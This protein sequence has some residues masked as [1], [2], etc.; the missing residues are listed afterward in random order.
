MMKRKMA[1]MMTGALLAMSATTLPAFAK[2]SPTNTQPSVGAH[3][4]KQVL[5]TTGTR[6]QQQKWSWQQNKGVMSRLTPS[7]Q[8]NLKQFKAGIDR[9]LSP[10]AAAKKVGITKV[11]RLSSINHRSQK[12]TSGR[13][14]MRLSLSQKTSATIRLDDRTKVVKVVRVASNRKPIQTLS[15]STK[16]RYQQRRIAKNQIRPSYRQKARSEE[17]RVGKEC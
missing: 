8:A 9:G 7:E 15:K 12:R 6:M 14:Q 13:Y 3:Q 16:A 5:R 2:V 17:R 11:T 4:Q 1:A 10:Q